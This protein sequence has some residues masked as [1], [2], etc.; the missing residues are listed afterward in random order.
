LIKLKYNY[1]WYNGID[2]NVYHILDMDF[3]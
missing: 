2:I 1:E 3:L